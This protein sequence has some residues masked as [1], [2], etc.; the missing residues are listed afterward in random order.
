MRIRH[1]L[2]TLNYPEAHAP[3]GLCVTMGVVLDGPLMKVSRKLGVWARLSCIH[4]KTALII[5][6]QMRLANLRGRATCEHATN[7][8]EESLSTRC[9]TIGTGQYQNN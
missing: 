1:S 9:F 6:K 5:H 4:L 7:D 3:F 8:V 2:R